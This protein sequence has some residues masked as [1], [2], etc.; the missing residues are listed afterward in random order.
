MQNNIVIYQE[1]DLSARTHIRAGEHKLGEQVLSF[2]KGFRQPV[3]I[4]MDMDSLVN[5]PSSAM[6]PSGFTVEEVRKFIRA[7]AL[8]LKCAYILYERKVILKITIT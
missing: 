6:T 8:N 3:G 5:M 2:F 7:M 4:E 1:T